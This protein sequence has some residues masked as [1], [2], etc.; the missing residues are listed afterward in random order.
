MSGVALLVLL[1]PL[2]FA[3]SH[4]TAQDDLDDKAKV[5]PCPAPQD[6]VPCTCYA[7]DKL[8][9]FVECQSLPSLAKL[10]DVFSKPF[11]FHKF[12]RL[13]VGNSYFGGETLTDDVFQNFT[14]R[15]VIFF[16]NNLGGVTLTAFENSKSELTSF[17]FLDTSAGF[18]LPADLSAYVQLRE[19]MVVSQS[20]EIPS[21]AAPKVLS[22]TIRST[23]NVT[24]PVA[25]T[26]LPE[27][28]TLHLHNSNLISVGG[29]VFTNSPKLMTVTLQ[30]NYLTSDALSLTFTNL[31]ELNLSSNKLSDMPLISGMARGS[32]VRISHNTDIRSLSKTST[33]ALL[34]GDVNIVADGITLK[35]DCDLRWLLGDDDA[36]MYLDNQLTVATECPEENTWSEMRIILD[37]L[38]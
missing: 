21:L 13:Q 22:L 27:L 37:S 7:D 1:L 4:T 23:Q 6:L 3:G 11:A 31:Y 36:T 10:K 18:P 32:T 30:N 35:C 28:T 14:F 12:A 15:E 8:N 2:L 25:P 19:I 26:N 24:L 38:C 33:E 9:L 17:E 20:A 34:Q 29:G 5:W 16:D